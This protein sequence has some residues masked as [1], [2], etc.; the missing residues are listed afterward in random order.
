MYE[1]NKLD[2]LLKMALLNIDTYNGIQ[3]TSTDWRKQ[4]HENAV[5]RF[6]NAEHIG[7]L[8]DIKMVR[9][10]FRNHIKTESNGIDSSSLIRHKF[11]SRNF[12]VKTR[13]DFEN[14]SVWPIVE[15]GNASLKI[16]DL[17]FLRTLMVDRRKEVRFM[18]F[19]ELR[20]RLAFSNDQQ[21]TVLRHPEIIA[22]IEGVPFVYPDPKFISDFRLNSNIVKHKSINWF[23]TLKDAP[24]FWKGI[25]C[26]CCN[27]STTSVEH[28]I[29]PSRIV[30]CHQCG[31]EFDNPQSI[32]S[33]TDLDKY[34]SRFDSKR[35]GESSKVRAKQNASIFMEDLKLTSPNHIN[36]SILDIGCSSGEFLA[37]LVKD[38][39]WAENNT[40]GI[41]PSP[42]SISDAR[43]NFNLQVSICDA[44]GLNTYKR[45][46]YSLIT[47]LN[48]VEHF[49]RPDIA[50][51]KMREVITS[52]GFLFIGTVPNV[53][54]LPS[55][56]SPNRFVA[57]NFPDGQHHFQ[58][59]PTTLSH[60]C[61]Q[62]GFAVARVL[63]RRRDIVGS[64]PEA[65][66]KWIAYT[67]GVSYDSF[68]NEFD[69]LNALR[70]RIEEGRAITKQKGTKYHFNIPNNTFTSIENFLSFWKSEIW[71]SPY[72]S[73]TFDLWLKPII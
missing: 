46:F 71:T 13:F 72:L 26:I 35:R 45:S 1:K 47:I 10:V 5:I 60:I 54:S 27:K 48:T 2:E 21:V 63:G 69:M 50:F 23:R 73:D 66:V 58:F 70:E 15:L 14:L 9:D 34:S 59:S 41:D 31:L 22:L 19:S 29:G 62:S 16:R 36:S 12:N 52:D 37:C 24:K 56:L 32:I 8:I 11:L 44:E 38:F 28:I 40:F 6:H 57:K 20:S 43:K 53:T 39:D 33:L 30:K 17:S 64:K 25:N 65:T 18:S 42:L 68:A 55:L 3:T 61:E 51:R 7:L 49:S 67:C 4:E